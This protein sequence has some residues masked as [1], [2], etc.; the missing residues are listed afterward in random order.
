MLKSKKAQG[1]S[2]NT[3]ILLILGLV[4][5]VALI[6]GFSTEWQSFKKITNPTNVDTLVEECQTACGLN[7]IYSFCSAERTLNVI[8]EDLQVKT[9][10]KVLATL[11]E[12]S[13]YRIGDCPSIDCDL[14]CEDIMIDGKKGQTD[15]ETATY[16]VSSLVGGEPCFIA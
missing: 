12:F 9:S 14:N 5:L 3:I 1:M 4:V 8:E 7:Q 11:P 2:T 15:L 6:W 10:C 16:D 13:K